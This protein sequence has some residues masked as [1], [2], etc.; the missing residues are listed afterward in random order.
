MEHSETKLGTEAI[1]A[2]YITFVYRSERYIDRD[3]G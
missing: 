3:R 1:N 2:T